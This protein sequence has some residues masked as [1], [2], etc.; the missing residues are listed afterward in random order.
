MSFQS[1]ATLRYQDMETGDMGDLPAQHREFPA[2]CNFYF[3]FLLSD[4][5]FTGTYL[6]NFPIY[7]VYFFRTV[8]CTDCSFSDLFHNRWLC[9]DRRNELC[10]RRW[11]VYDLLCQ[12]VCI[13]CLCDPCKEKPATSSLT[14]WGGR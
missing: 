12:S 3:V 8:L 5:N 13:P 9:C 14:A 10:N 2:V 6:G 11:S 4:R 7:I 1:L